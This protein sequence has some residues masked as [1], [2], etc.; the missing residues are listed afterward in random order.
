MCPDQLRGPPI[1][2]YRGSF[3]QG[4][5]ADAW[6]G[7]LSGSDEIKNTYSPPHAILEHGGTKLY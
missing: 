1:L 6:T 7:S 4:K 5:A 2:Y 3:P